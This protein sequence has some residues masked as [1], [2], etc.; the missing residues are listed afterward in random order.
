MLA[1][2][3]KLMARKRLLS[4]RLAKWIAVSF[5]AL[6]VIP[7]SNCV[8]LAFAAG[9]VWLTSLVIYCIFWLAEQ[10]ERRNRRD[11]NDGEPAE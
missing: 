1:I 5:F 4:Y 7:I 6:S 9:L 8:G 3:L 10:C 2:L 11:N